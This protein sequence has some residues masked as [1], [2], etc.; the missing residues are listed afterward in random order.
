MISFAWLL[1]WVCL[2]GVLIALAIA[3]ADVVTR[4]DGQWRP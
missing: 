4:P 1:F 3:V 2:A